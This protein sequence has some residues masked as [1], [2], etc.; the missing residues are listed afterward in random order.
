[1]AETGSVTLDTPRYVTAAV[2]LLHAA[3]IKAPR[4]QAKRHFARVHGGGTLDLAR[5]KLEGRGDVLFRVVLDHSEYRGKI[6]FAPFRKQL[7]QLIGRLAER[8]RLKLDIAVYTSEATGELLFN[9]PSITKNEGTINVL[10][11]GVGKPEPGIT[12]LRLQFLDP[13]QFRKPAETPQTAGA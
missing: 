4:A 3:F 13:E 1:M 9:V 6:G 5:L 7:E 10:M 11:L 12:T 8:V 2:N